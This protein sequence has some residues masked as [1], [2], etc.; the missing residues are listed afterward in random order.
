MLS[1]TFKK[2]RRSIV[3]FAS[4]A[5][6]SK[7]GR[8]PSFPHL[9][10][11]G[12]V[13]DTRGIVAT[14]RHVVRALEK[15]PN[16]PKTGAS[17][18]VALTFS[19]VWEDGE[20]GHL[21]RV[22]PISLRRWDKL[23]TF[24][25]SEDFFGGQKPDLAFVQL[26]VAGLPA[27]DLVTENGSWEVGTPIATAGFPLGTR[28]LAIYGRI[29]QVAPILRSGIIASVYPFPCPRPHGFTVDIMTLGGE[30][31]SPIFFADSPRVVGLLH[32]GFNGTNITL[33][34]PSSLVALAFDHYMNTVPLDFTGVPLF[35]EVAV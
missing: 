24:T 5:V 16:N 7:R 27:A 20:G 10:G 23:A 29:N 15:L 12:F 18:A 17:A 31:G 13:I 11:T 14:N 35:E 4:M 6:A 9:I 26:N 33:A 19:D 3:G 28:A 22:V 1:E 30:S 25:S 34:V 32:G 8:R 2:L 21:L